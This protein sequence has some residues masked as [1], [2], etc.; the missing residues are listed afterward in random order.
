MHEDA[1]Q[2]VDAANRF[3]TVERAADRSSDRAQDHRQ[4]QG[5]EHAQHGVEV[6]QLLHLVRVLVVKSK[7]HQEGAEEEDLRHQRLDHSALVSEE[8]RNED[9]KHDDGVDDHAVLAFEETSS[10]RASMTRK[11]PNMPTMPTASLRG[12]A[13]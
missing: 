5:H 2:A 8:E 1:E 13:M 11:P 6:Q 9:R 10:R 7:D 12:C 4:D 3:E